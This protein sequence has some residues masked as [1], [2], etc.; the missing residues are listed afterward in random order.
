MT[1][2]FLKTDVIK[3]KVRLDPQQLEAMENEL[4]NYSSQIETMNCK[5]YFWS[6]LLTMFTYDG[7][8]AFDWL[9]GMFMLVCELFKQLCMFMLACELFK[10]L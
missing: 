6:N 10:Q 1:V 7:V 4:K 8:R 9:S 3:R 5:T 2:E